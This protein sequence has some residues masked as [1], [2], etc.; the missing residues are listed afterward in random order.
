MISA[1]NCT[2][3]ILSGQLRR[4]GARGLKSLWH[5]KFWN[6]VDETGVTKFQFYKIRR[7]FL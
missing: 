3:A 2:K 1:N 7:C 4:P 5:I 6:F